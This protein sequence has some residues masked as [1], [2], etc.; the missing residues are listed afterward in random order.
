MAPLADMFQYDFMVRAVVGGLLVSLL[1]SVLSLFVLLKRLAFAGVGI[2]HA[3][4][5]GISLGLVTGVN[6]LLTALL[7]CVATAFGIGAVSRTGRLTEDVAI[8]ILTTGLMAFGVVLVGFAGT[9][10]GDL[11]SYLF[12]NILAVS[13]GQLVSLA[14][15][16]VLVLGFIGFFYKE[17]LFVSFDEEVARVTGVPARLLGYGLLVAIACTV[18]AAIHVVGLVLASALLVIPAAVGFQMADNWRGI[19]GISILSGWLAVFIGLTSS[20]LWDLASGGSI[21]LALVMLFFAAFM[22]RRVRDARPA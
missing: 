18:V 12:G 4:L 19:L 21:V 20:Y 2:S 16:A 6:P 13:T 11:F 5:G 10:Q 9:Y 15:V 22:V 3:A 7:V 8:G 1:C 14:G 17:L